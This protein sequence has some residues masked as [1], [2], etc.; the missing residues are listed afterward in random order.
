MNKLLDIALAPAAFAAGFFL[1]SLRKFGINRLP[2]SLQALRKAGIFPIQRHYYEPL[3]DPR[4]LRSTETQERHLPGIDW[5][6]DQQLKFLEKFQFA[7]ELAGIFDHPDTTGQF[8][9]NNGMFE[10]GDAEYWY[11]LLRQTKP[12]RLV[13]IGSGYSTLLSVAAL[14]KNAEEG[15]SAPPE[16]ICIEPYGAT[17]LDQLPLTILKQ[18][19][20]TVDSALFERLEEG[21]VLFIDSS[22]MIRPQGDVLFEFLEVLPRLRPGVIVHVHDIFSPRDYPLSWLSTEVRFWNEQYLLEAFLSGNKDWEI[23]GA[24]NYLHHRYPDELKTVCPFLTPDREPG[25]FY[26]RR[27]R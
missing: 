13:E 22:H 6:P 14:Q 9:F 16:H 5:Q 24:L 7:D 1:R 3:F 4:D 21:D 10:S 26:I 20:E 11:Q 25:S 27:L 18:P 17:W 8:H 2:R 23:V 19:V 15:Q 12:Q